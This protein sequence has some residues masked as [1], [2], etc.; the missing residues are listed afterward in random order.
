MG[1]DKLKGVMKAIHSYIM[2]TLIRN[3]LEFLETK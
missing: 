2:F 1:K 3:Y